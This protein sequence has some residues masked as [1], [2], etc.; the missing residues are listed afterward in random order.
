MLRFHHNG[1]FPWPDLREDWVAAGTKD[2]VAVAQLGETSLN[3]FF[4]PGKNESHRWAAAVR[5]CRAAVQPR[6]IPSHVSI[7]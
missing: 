6:Y 7:W 1:G 4:K 2:Y 3:D 5:Q